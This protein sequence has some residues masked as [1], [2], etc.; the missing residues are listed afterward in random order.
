M[1]EAFFRVARESLTDLQKIRNIQYSLSEPLSP[2]PI[3]P[4]PAGRDVLL[5]ILLSAS[6][7]RC[8]GYITKLLCAAIL[9]RESK[10]AFSL[11]RY[12]AEIILQMRVSKVSDAEEMYVI[13]RQFIV[14][15]GRTVEKWC[16]DLKQQK[17]LSPPAFDIFKKKLNQ[18]CT[19][20]TF[21]T[22]PIGSLAQEVLQQLG[23]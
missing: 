9:E 7:V 19:E 22:H 8:Q 1:L 12:W 16:Y 15:L 14:Y 23:D 20:G 21:Y 11:L 18:W 17:L 6:E 5:A 10:L 13:F 2:Q 3:I 4:D